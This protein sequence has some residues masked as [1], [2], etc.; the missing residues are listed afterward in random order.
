MTDWHI[1][2]DTP[3]KFDYL[4]SLVVRNIK[5]GKILPNISFSFIKKDTLEVIFASRNPLRVTV[6]YLSHV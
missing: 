6:T 5:C 3:Y 1:G 2:F 4:A